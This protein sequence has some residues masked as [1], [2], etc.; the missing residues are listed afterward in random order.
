M[1]LKWLHGVQ[2]TLAEIPVKPQPQRIHQ[3][4]CPEY[5][6]AEIPVKPQLDV[7]SRG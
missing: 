7:E 3:Q 1:Q 5:T 2:Y 6:L 4:L